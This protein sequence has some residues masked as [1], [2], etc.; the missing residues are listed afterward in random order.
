MSVGFS[1]LGMSI[2]KKL[3]RLSE[4][5]VIKKSHDTQGSVVRKL[6]HLWYTFSLRHLKFK[7][8]YVLIR[9]AD[10]FYLNFFWKLSKTYV[11]PHPMTTYLLF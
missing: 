6:Q 8:Q 9:L 2:F 4:I 3:R 1:A 10:L 7:S 11:I 5:Q